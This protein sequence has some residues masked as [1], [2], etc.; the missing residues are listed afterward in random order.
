A[1][2]GF[3]CVDQPNLKARF[4]RE[5]KSPGDWQAVSNG[6]ETFHEDAGDRVRVR[7]AEA[8]PI[9][10]YLFAFAAGKFQIETAER[11]GRWYRMFHRETDA[12]KV[13]R[14]RKAVFDLHAS[15]LEWLEKYTGIPYRF[16]KFDFVLIPSFHFS[17]MEAPG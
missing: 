11:N 16:G 7:Y 13:E 14:N 6:A 5:L 3:Q 12:K 1:H 15:S 2:P 10:T 17:G 4:S 9:P 8:Q